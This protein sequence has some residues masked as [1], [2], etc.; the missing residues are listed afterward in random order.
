METD[1]YRVGLHGKVF[2]PNWTPWKRALYRV[3][4]D[5][6][7]FVPSWTPLKRLFTE[8]ASMETV[9]YRVAPHGNVLCTELASMDTVFCIELTSMETVLYKLHSMET[10]SVP[11]GHHAVVVL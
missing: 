3:G 7:G 9:S 10:C 4:L 2:V 8:L 6:N 1:L 11:S 5:G